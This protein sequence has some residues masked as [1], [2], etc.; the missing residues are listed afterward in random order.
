MKPVFVGLLAVY[1][2]AL[3]FLYAQAA[4]SPDQA[5]FAYV[6]WL[7]SEGATL[8]V[9]V[10][11]QNWPGAMWLHGLAVALFGRSTVSI[12]ILEMVIVLLAAL[13]A[14]ELLPKSKSDLQTW[15]LFFV[16]PLMY[17]ASGNWFVGQR[18]IIAG[19]VLVIGAAAFVRRTKGGHVAWLLLVAS[20]L[21]LATMI[22]PTFLICGPLLLL[23]AALTRRE[24]ELTWKR[25]GLDGAL[26]IGA[27]LALLAALVLRGKATGGFDAFWAQSVDFN[28]GAY[29]GGESQWRFFLGLELKYWALCLPA[30]FVGGL[31]WLTSG[32][33]RVE[34]GVVAAL[35]LTTVV[36]FTVMGKGFGYHL[37]GLHPPFAILVTVG[38]AGAVEVVKA[39]R[40]LR[41]R[42][43]A[44]LLALMTLAG[45]GRNFMRDLDEPTKWALGLA[46]T[47][48]MRDR[49]VFSSVWKTSDY[50]AAAARIEELTDEDD[51]VL[52]WARLAILNFLAARRLPFVW[53][54]PSVLEVARPPFRH[55]ERWQR[56]A[57]ER[58]ERDPPAMIVTQLLDDGETVELIMP[59]APPTPYLAWVERALAED[60]VQVDRIG[61][62]QL[63]LRKDLAAKR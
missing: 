50:H 51:T 27:F 19:N 47:E 24:S 18:D 36:S 61:Y 32:R 9:D 5:T 10:G 21:F 48:Q 23:V 39:D 45:L 22:R 35:A 12:H 44:G 55:A 62:M 29:Q 37:G 8:Y 49:Q 43:T 16:Y 56:E 20:A 26:T 17:A 58:L 40:V 63:F 15:L 33:Y 13:G 31:A 60:Y 28:V 59:D 41:R 25:I 57:V 34:L 52:T 2:A 46:T 7:F 54:T 53:S 38:L 4:L 6:G 11:E 42:L 14:R 1:L 3:T 30:A